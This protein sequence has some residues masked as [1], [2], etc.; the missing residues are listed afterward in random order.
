MKTDLLD[1]I[2]L[3]L[4]GLYEDAKQTK[5][6]ILFD[7][8][9]T[10][11]RVFETDVMPIVKACEYLNKY[12][13]FNQSSSR[14]LFEFRLTNYARDHVVFDINLTSS[15]QIESSYDDKY[16]NLAKRQ[17]KLAGIEL[18][19]AENTINMSI[20]LATSK[21]PPRQSLPSINQ[22]ILKKYH[23]II[24]YPDIKGFDIL[25]SQ[26]EH[27]GINVRPTNDYLSAFEHIINPIYTPNLVFIHKNDI[28][29]EQDKKEILKA[30]K[31]KGFSVIII[32][33]NDVNLKGFDEFFILNQPYTY[34]M[35]YAIISVSYSRSLAN[36]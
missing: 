36:S 33:E 29:S 6:I 25:K 5:N 17:I 16:L 12:L 8:A 18:K 27:L 26:L 35:L 23:A 32:C 14:V 11:P 20:K 30:K 10:Y 24:S 3:L 13:L 9:L 28:L 22:S 15:K 1:R 2:S 7:Y 31:T 4:E 34:D 21:E 19:L